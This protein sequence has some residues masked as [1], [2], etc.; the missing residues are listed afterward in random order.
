M[1]CIDSTLLCN[2][3]NGIGEATYIIVVDSSESQNDYIVWPHNGLRDPS[4]YRIRS[5][6]LLPN[7]SK[8]LTFNN[9]V[10]ASMIYHNDLLEISIGKNK[11][12]FIMVKETVSLYTKEIYRILFGLFN[13]NVKKHGADLIAMTGTDSLAISCNYWFNDKDM[14]HKIGTS[15]SW[16]Y[17]LE[18]DSLVFYKIMGDD[19]DAS[20]SLL[21]KKDF[22]IKWKCD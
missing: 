9:L 7:E 12:H 2:C 18:N 6:S 13:E 3:V 17:Q 11:Y 20:D 19:R 1:Q 8:V 5:D 10:L 4:T 16:V 14:L 22:G 15:V 21:L